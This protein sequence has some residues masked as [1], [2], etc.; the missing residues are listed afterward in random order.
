MDVCYTTGFDEFEQWHYADYGPSGRTSIVCLRRQESKGEVRSYGG[1]YYSVWYCTPS[2]RVASSRAGRL[3]LIGPYGS[4]L[5]RR[6]FHIHLN[7]DISDDSFLLIDFLKDW[8][9][10]NVE[11]R[12]SFTLLYSER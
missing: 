3:S 8:S 12:F 9:I 1:L 2:T 7:M 4:T 5:N 10:R 11:H 6:F